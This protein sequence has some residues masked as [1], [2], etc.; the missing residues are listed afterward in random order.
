VVSAALG[1]DPDRRKVGDVR[2]AIGYLESG[3]KLAP[4]KGKPKTGRSSGKQRPKG[5]ET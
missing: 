4:A 2:K 1:D 3:F 5:T